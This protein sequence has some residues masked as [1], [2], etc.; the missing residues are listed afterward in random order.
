MQASSVDL[1]RVRRGGRLIFAED[2]RLE[3][4]VN[5]ALHRRAIAAGAQAIATVLVV[6]P[7]AH[8]RLEP[9][10]EALA[11]A[12]SECGATAL[13]GMLIARLLSPDA[14]ALRA[15]LA[16]LMGRLTHAPLPRSWQT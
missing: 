6:S 4:K 8:E 14:A 2:V 13:D 9:A 16:R 10:R 11:D 3:G 7:D 12:V 5:L 1:G 15:D